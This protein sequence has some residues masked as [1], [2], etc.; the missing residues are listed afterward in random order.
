MM[1]KVQAARQLQAGSSGEAL[2]SFIST[3][4]YLLEKKD[5]IQQVFSKD[6]NDQKTERFALNENVDSIIISIDSKTRNINLS[7]KELEIQDEKEALSKYG[8]SDSGASL[9][10]ILGSVLKK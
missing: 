9:G 10:D 5:A 6:K 2:A 4:E 7:I 1:D 8:S 3:C